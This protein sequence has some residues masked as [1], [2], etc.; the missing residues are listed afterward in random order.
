MGGWAATPARG[1]PRR[2]AAS[3]P[4]STVL[5][6]RK[7]VDIVVVLK[8][9]EVD[10]VDQ[11]PDVVLDRLIE[12]LSPHYPGKTRKGNRSVQ[13][14]FSV[15]G[16]IDEQV[17]SFDVVPAFA[18][19]GAYTIP[20]PRPGGWIKTTRASTRRRRPPPTRRSPSSGSRS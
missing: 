18:D 19:G 15:S 4:S 17:A 13:V 10:Y 14:D 7:D 2:Y 12:I 16:A 1:R 8:G 20:A 6:W 11:S 5:R 9:S 3:R